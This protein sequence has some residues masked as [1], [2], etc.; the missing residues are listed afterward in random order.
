MVLSCSSANISIQ[1]SNFPTLSSYRTSNHDE[2]NRIEL[3]GIG[4]RREGN[5]KV[6]VKVEQV[7]QLDL[8]IPERELVQICRPGSQD[9]L[10][11]QERLVV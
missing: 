1:S 3:D 11:S 6:V 5:Q 7:P 2:V 8:G 9:Q 4:K 10:G